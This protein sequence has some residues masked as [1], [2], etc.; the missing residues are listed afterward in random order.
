M[1][2]PARAPSP[3][4]S[5]R[6]RARGRAR[7]DARGRRGASPRV[8]AWSSVVVHD[9]DVVPV[10]VEHEGGVIARV[11]DGSLAGGAVVAVAGR[12]GVA[13]EAVDRL[14]VRRREREMDVLGRA[15]AGDDREGSA[16]ARELRPVAELAADAETGRGPDRLVEARRGVD[17]GDADPEVVDVPALAQRPVVDG[18]DAVP[19]RV[20]EKGAVAVVRSE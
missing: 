18:L 1:A 4:A 7:P 6:P 17:V 11:V 3:R 5:G 14:V 16:D 15:L 10:R 13:M 12:G 9:L 8:R 2:E 20:Q 19:V